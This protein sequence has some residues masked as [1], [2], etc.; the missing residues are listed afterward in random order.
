MCVRVP[1]CPRC[2]LVPS[3]VGQTP[4]HRREPESGNYGQS[5]FLVVLACLCGLDTIH[6][7]TLLKFIGFI[8]AT[9]IHAAV[10]N[11][12]H[13]FQTFFSPVGE[14]GCESLVS[15]TRVSAMSKVSWMC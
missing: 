6:P 14:E 13:S 11:S 3:F 2:L 1:W 7:L 5:F 9:Q 8:C 4:A 15:E 12:G 10:A